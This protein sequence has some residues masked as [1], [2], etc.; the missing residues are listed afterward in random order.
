MGDHTK[1]EW[2][3]ATW[4]VVTG[5][6]KVSPGCDRCYIDRSAPFRVEGR[7]FLPIRADGESKVGQSTGVL[8]H[9][10]RLDQP[11]RWRR[12]RRVFV[13]SLADL[14]HDDVP[15]DYIA[16]VFAVMA[17]APDHIF[18][19]LTKRHGRMKALLNS[20]DFRWRVWHAMLAITHERS[21]PMPEGL[22]H[23]GTDDQLVWPLPN[24]WVGV[25]VED[26][27][28]ADLR[29]PAL[30]DTPA[31]VRFLSCEPL[32]GEV[33]LARTFRA[34]RPNDDHPWTG[35]QLAAR[36]VL[37]W[38]IAGGESGPGARP[39]HPEWA[40]SLRDQCAAAG[41][42]YF[43]KQWGEWAPHRID[44]GAHT[45][46]QVTAHRSRHES[47]RFRPNGVRYQPDSAKMTDGVD[48]YSA[49]GMVSMLRVGKRAAGR[50][51]DGRTWDEQPGLDPERH[52]AQQ[53]RRE[54]LTWVAKTG[55]ARTD[56]EAP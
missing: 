10:D 23:P 8:L 14:F 20:R 38:V 31:A 24:V 49:P 54:A 42:T 37:H 28:R 12:P 51:L 7:T 16:R 3:D 36:Q 55:S 18:Q 40:R 35:H 53:A 32:L 11:L 41:I 9:P 15:A 50:T 25:S 44:G 47:D 5:C 52:R 45:N 46:H 43:F 2:A 19:V 26:Q 48:D 30:I 39:M 4:N 17:L 27:A 13:N 29:V 1:I 21:L 33:D 6:T 34:C 56:Q 22:T